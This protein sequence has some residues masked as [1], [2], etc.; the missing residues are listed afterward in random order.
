M[1]PTPSFPGPPQTPPDPASAD[2]PP[3]LRPADSLLDLEDLPLQVHLL[4]MEVAT[5]RKALAAM[6]AM[7]LALAQ[8]SLPPQPAPI[9]E[10]PNAP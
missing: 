2:L 10:S 3:Y 1:T 7:F 8:A 4:T 6:S 9:G 5:Q